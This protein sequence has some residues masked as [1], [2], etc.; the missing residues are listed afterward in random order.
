MITVR[1]KYFGAFRDLEKKADLSELRFETPVS[2]SDL[3]VALAD[4]FRKI[5]GNDSAER[6]VQDSAIANDEKVL[7]RG[8]LV[9]GDCTLLLLPPVCGG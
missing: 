4:G 9:A 6:L 2:I 7:S 1:S 5:M 8:H 3:K